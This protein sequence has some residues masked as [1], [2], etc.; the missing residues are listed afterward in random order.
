M[1]RGARQTVVL[2]KGGRAA[3]FLADEMMHEVLPTF[4]TRYSCN[5]WY[6][7]QQERDRAEQEVRARG[8][9]GGASGGLATSTGD[10]AE[11]RAFLGELLG[12]GSDEAGGSD[13]LTRLATLAARLPPGAAQVVAQVLGAG[14]GPSLDVAASVRALTPEALASLRRD[15][16]MMGK[17]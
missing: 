1:V 17:G 7:D 16:S 10:Q 3:L 6:Y 14:S 4:R 9:I 8:Q 15:L 12:R 2:P 11:A 13:D 5:V